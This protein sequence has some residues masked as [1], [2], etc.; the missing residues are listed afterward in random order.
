MKETKVYEFSTFQEF[1]ERV[2]ADRMADCLAELA[3]NFSMA[4][5]MM[6][7]IN[8][9]AKSLGGSE[10]KSLFQM[11][12]V[13]HDDKKGDIKSILGFGSDANGKKQSIAIVAKRKE[14]A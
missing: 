12:L 10:Y 9:I 6:G 8:P 13:W 4:K 1:F 5:S 7:V 2:P 14:K 11:P 3:I